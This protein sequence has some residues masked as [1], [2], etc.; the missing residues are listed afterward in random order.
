MILVLTLLTLV[1]RLI[2]AF[3]DLQQKQQQPCPCFPMR[4]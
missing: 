3:A 2:E 4:R 1:L